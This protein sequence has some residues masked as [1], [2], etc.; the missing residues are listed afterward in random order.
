MV[1]GDLWCL[2]SRLLVTFVVLKTLAGHFWIVRNRLV[3]Y[4]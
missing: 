1:N 4:D 2:I 3:P